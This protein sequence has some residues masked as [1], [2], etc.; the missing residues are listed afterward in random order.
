MKNFSAYARLIPHFG[1]KPLN[2][3]SRVRLTGENPYAQSS[4][5][6]ENF[7]E[8]YGMKGSRVN[9]CYDG[10][11]PVTA[12]LLANRYML[13]TLDRGYDNLFTLA[14]TEGKLYLYKNNYSLPLG[15]MITSPN[16][17]FDDAQN[18]AENIHEDLATHEI[19]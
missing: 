19:N 17:R 3:S 8:T 10:A 15:Y 2:N 12:A 1:A 4:Q 16:A 7:Y 11:T 13:Y 9:Y 14:D 18:V 5:S 6:F